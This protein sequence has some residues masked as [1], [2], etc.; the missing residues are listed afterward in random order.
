M[1]AQ[2]GRQ[3]WSMHSEL[4]QATEQFVLCLLFWCCQTVHSKAWLK[5]SKLHTGETLGPWDPRV[6]EIIK[7]DLGPHSCRCDELHRRFVGAM[8]TDDAR[9]L[10]QF[11]TRNGEKWKTGQSRHADEEEPVGYDGLATRYPEK[12]HPDKHGG[13]AGSYYSNSGWKNYGSWRGQSSTS[14]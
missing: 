1:V 10:Q 12:Q 9:P 13:F 11:I 6:M 5:A 3:I 7:D 8:A 4:W 2:G 14:R